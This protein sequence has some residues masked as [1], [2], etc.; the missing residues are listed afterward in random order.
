[1]VT[2]T[3]P[4][5]AICACTYKRPEGLRKLLNGL[6]KQIFA[7]LE[8][9][10]GRGPGMAIVIADN[11]GSEAARNV[12]TEFRLQRSDV[13]LTYTH[14]EK[15]GIS[16]ARNACLDHVPVGADFIA[17]LD[18]DEIPNPDWLDNLLLAQRATNA[19][20][21]VGCVMP[22][23]DEGTPAWIA[24]GDFFGRPK[25]TYELDA[26]D[27]DDLTRLTWSG[28]GNVLIRAAAVRDLALRFDPVHALS[29]GEDTAFFAQMRKNGCE[30]VYSKHAVAYEYCPPERATFA[31]LAAER[32][33]MANVNT[34]LAVEDAGR[35]ARRRLAAGSTGLTHLGSGFR[36]VLT[37]LVAGRWSKDRFATGAFRIAYGLGMIA[38]AFGYRYQHYR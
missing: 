10:D 26:R 34:L 13:P 5:V 15:R 2:G 38:G 18:D 12:C 11:E 3:R 33:R 17:M 16:H 25:R 27:Y 29:G 32:F 20:I 36:R 14:E 22:I 30:I 31:Y 37:T 28:S 19:D 21:V 24:G 23:F 1:M 35:R 8:E 6:A 4:F 7:G 9:A